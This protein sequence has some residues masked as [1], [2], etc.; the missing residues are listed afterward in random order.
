MRVLAKIISIIFH[1]LLMPTYGLLVIF[2]SPSFVNYSLSFD[3]KLY[4]VLYVFFY[5]FVT[6]VFVTLFL[7]KRRIVSS[8]SLPLR[9]ERMIPYI[10]SIV[11]TSVVLFSLGK[12]GIPHVMFLFIQGVLIA[13]ILSFLINFFWKI[14]AHAVGIGGLIGCLIALHIKLHADMLVFIS[15]AIL[16]AGLIFSTS[17]YLIAHG[18]LQ[19]AAGLALGFFVEIIFML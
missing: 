1:P 10:L 7:W 14:S 19:I 18:G 8:L 12:K 16:I 5:C 15:A 3:F 17:L 4:L 11:M 2:N 6:P 13:V 9:K